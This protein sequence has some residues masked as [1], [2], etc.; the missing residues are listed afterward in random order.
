VEETSAGAAPGGEE[1]GD[2]PFAS[3]AAGTSSATPSLPLLAGD[4]FFAARERVIREGEAVTVAYETFGAPSAASALRI[5]IVVELAIIATPWLRP[6][7]FMKR[8]STQLMSRTIK[9]PDFFWRDQ[10]YLSHVDLLTNTGQ[11]RRYC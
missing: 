11:P 9:K 2:A 10:G 6:R 8:A 3:L 7:M 5:C 4:A 1:G